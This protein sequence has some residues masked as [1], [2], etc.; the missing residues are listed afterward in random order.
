MSLKK[1][2]K[3]D[4]VQVR[5]QGPKKSREIKNSRFSNSQPS[6]HTLWITH[7]EKAAAPSPPLNTEC[8]NWWKAF[9][10]KTAIG[11][12]TTFTT[13]QDWRQTIKFHNIHLSV[14]VAQGPQIGELKNTRL[15]EEIQN[16]LSL[17]ESVTGAFLELKHL[18]LDRSLRVVAEVAPLVGKV[19]QVASL[20]SDNPSIKKV[21]ISSRLK[22]EKFIVQRLSQGQTYR[23][24]ALKLGKIQDSMKTLA[25]LSQATNHKHLWEETYQ[26]CSIK[27]SATITRNH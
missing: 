5:S 8:L 13:T 18:T 15:Q 24:K 19:V 25:T 9:K 4:L 10:M 23:K 17:A 3:Q 2:K 7:Q 27:L 6:T 12:K 20:L 21:A 16:L 26:I 14:W 11:G 1:R 22:V